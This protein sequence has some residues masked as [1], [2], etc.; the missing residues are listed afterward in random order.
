MSWCAQSKGLSTR[1]LALY[2]MLGALMFCSK[3]ITEALPNI[4]LVGMLTM[5]CA[6]SFGRR[7]LIPVYIFVLLTGIFGG[8]A[9]WWIPY[10]Y[11]WALLWLAC[12]LLPKNM[13]RRVAAVVYPIVCSLH[14]FC[15]G[16]LYAPAQALLFG[17]NFKQTLAW[18]AAGL[19][20]DI[21]HGISNLFTGLMVLPLTELCRRLMNGGREKGKE[22]S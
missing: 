16:V 3:L 19:P 9:F 11:I 14:G 12:M 8:F 6:L 1:E 18:I 10:L 13:P 20:F 5:V 21:I 17:L 15:F 4:H 7:G 2:G 22:K